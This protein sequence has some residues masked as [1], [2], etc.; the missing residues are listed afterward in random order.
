MNRCLIT[1]E[2]CGTALY[3]TKGLSLLSKNLNDLKPLPFSAAEQRRE[4]VL[5]I[6]KMSIQ[7][8]QPK[9]SA[10]LNVRQQQFDLTN[11]GG[12]FILKPQHT[13]FE[14]LPQNEALSMRLAAFCGLEVP[15]SGLV[16]S[17]DGSLTY[18]VKRFDRFGKGKK[19]ATEDFA[20]LS[21]QT[22]ETKYRSSMEK[23]GEIID[24]FCSFPAVEKTKL[25]HLVL[26]NFLIGNEDAHLKN[27]SLINVKD[28][29]TLSP[30]YDLVNST[31]VL[32]GH[33]IEETALPLNGKKRKLTR[34]LL[35]RYYAQERLKLTPKS[36]DIIL[37]KISDA[38]PDW[39]NLI[40]WSFLSDDMKTRYR[41]LLAE[42]LKILGLS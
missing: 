31:I 2:P 18:F 17:K 30:C 19:L 10:K 37:Q 33:N 23:V 38:Q 14:E 12:T 25:F 34:D 15:L 24:T 42:R 13:D 28:K 32:N 20:Q 41:A 6:E 39:Q 40:S 26:F 5:R 7:G 8:V 11:I 9:L 36:V 22:R 3:S 21:N 16:L 4:A 35:I 1:Y 29:I 27:F